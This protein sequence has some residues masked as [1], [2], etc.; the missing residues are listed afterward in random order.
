MRGTRDIY[1]SKEKVFYTRHTESTSNQNHF[2]SKIQHKWTTFLQKQRRNYRYVCVIFTNTNLP[3][4]S[5]M[6]ISVFTF[7]PDLLRNQNTITQFVNKAYWLVLY[8]HSHS[9]MYVCINIYINKNIHIHIPPLNIFIQDTVPGSIQTYISLN[10]ENIP[11]TSREK[12]HY[13]QNP[14]LYDFYLFLNS[15]LRRR[16]II[17]IAN[18]S[19]TL[20]QEYPVVF[21]VTAPSILRCSA[22]A[23]KP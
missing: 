4:G 9:Y 19:F 14:L 23:A 17:T 1:R 18:A 21:D 10:H 15:K 22:L 20:F 8:R 3:A 11:I 2:Y 12:R 5:A 13:L 6:P 16:E 7:V